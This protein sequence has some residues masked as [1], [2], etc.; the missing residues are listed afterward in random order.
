MQKKETF[1]KFGKKSYGYW[2]LRVSGEEHTN[3][4]RSYSSKIYTNGKSN[5]MMKLE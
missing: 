1:Q 4:K 2:K 5:R 3:G